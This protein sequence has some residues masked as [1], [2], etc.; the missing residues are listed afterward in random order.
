MIGLQLEHELHNPAIFSQRH[1]NITTETPRSSLVA[2]HAF[3]LGLKQLS[4]RAAVKAAGS[5]LK[6]R[7]YTGGNILY[8]YC[9]TFDK[10]VRLIDLINNIFIN[11]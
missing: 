3:I 9:C 2:A 11:L 1:D 8:L 4:A 6:G 5:G 10:C 7:L